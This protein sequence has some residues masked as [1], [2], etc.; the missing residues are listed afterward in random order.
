[1]KYQAVMQFSERDPIRMQ[2]IKIKTV[3]TQL[4]LNA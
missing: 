3:I 4:C 2:S 1:M